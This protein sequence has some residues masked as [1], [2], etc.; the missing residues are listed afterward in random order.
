[1]RKNWEKEIKISKNNARLWFCIN[2]MENYFAN[3]Q[4]TQFRCFYHCILEHVHQQHWIHDLHKLYHHHRLQNWFTKKKIKKIFSCFLSS[5][6]VI[7]SPD[8]SRVSNIP[9]T[10]SNLVE[11]LHA[12][13]SFNAFFGCKTSGWRIRMMNYNKRNCFVYV[14]NLFCC[15]WAPFSSA[16]NF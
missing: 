13:H 2:P 12:L 1:M 16:H 15:L 4:S 7:W 9:P 6:D 5:S 3:H 14:F 10:T 11:I 8:D